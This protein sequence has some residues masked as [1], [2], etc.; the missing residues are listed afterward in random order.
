MA[1]ARKILIVDPDPTMARQLA[2]AL[3]QQGYQ[4]H[5]ARDGTRAL[6]VAILRFPDLVLFDERTPLI[7]ARTFLRI[8]RTNPRTERIPVVLT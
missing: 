6:Q 4:V 2:P 3:R 1:Q 8:L 5:A 7:D